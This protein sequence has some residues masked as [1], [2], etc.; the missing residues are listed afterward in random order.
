MRRKSVEIPLQILEDDYSDG[1]SIDKLSL[2][3]LIQIEGAQQAHRHD[4]HFFLLLEKGKVSVEI[5]FEKYNLEEQSLFYLHPHQVH[6]ILKLKNTTAYILAVKNEWLQRDQIT[7]LDQIAPLR[8]LVPHADALFLLQQSIQLCMAIHQ[9]KG[10]FYAKA[11]RDAVKTFISLFIE[12]FL[13]AFNP[14]K[15]PS[16]SEAIAYKFHLLI[17]QNFIAQ[18][19]PGQYAQQLNI[20][21]AYLNECITKTTGLSASYHINQRVILEAKRLL[22]HADESVKEIAIALGFDD[23]AYFSRLFKKHVGTTAIN[24]RK[25]SQA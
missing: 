12:Q 6:R 24:F 25:T 3:D 20:S 17:Q 10:P 22:Y 8:P 16:R 4:F 7:T 11:L 23:V 15:K 1:F 21:T 13:G 2:E 19:R 9:Q 14:A 18:K 5:D